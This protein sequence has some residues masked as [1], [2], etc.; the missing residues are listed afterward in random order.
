[1]SAPAF[2]QDF[3]T[4]FNKHCIDCHSGDFVEGGLD[5]DELSRDFSDAEVRRRWT[6]LHDR[7]ANGEMPPKEKYKPDNTTRATFLSGLGDS[8]TK[9]DLESR[10]VVLRRLNRK[11]YENTVR[12]LFGIYIELHRILPDETPE[13]GFDKIGSD[14]SVSAE[15]MEIYLQAADLV[16]DQVFGPDRAPQTTEI[17][18]NL[19]D[20]RALSE[21]DPR[22]DRGAYLHSR[23]KYGMYETS[24]RAPGRYRFNIQAK[25]INTDK[26]MVLNVW[27][28]NTGAIAPH[29]AG[30]FLVY[31][32]EMQT[33]EVVDWS[34]ERGDSWALE[35]VHGYSQ[36]KVPDGYEG[37]GIFVTDVEVEGPL[38]EWPPTSRS[39]L[40]GNIDLESGTIQN[41]QT[42]LTKITPRVFR[43]TTSAEELEP[44]LQLAQ[45]ALDEG[46]GF[47]RGLRRALKGIL[48][49]PEFLYLEES[50]TVND[51]AIAARLSYFLW[52]STP[53]D[54]LL[55]L[56]HQELLR[57]PEILRQQVERML[58]DEK[59]QRFVE[60]FTAQWLRLQDIDF[61]VPDR[62][63]YPEY[64]QLLRE[65]MLDETRAFFREI[66]DN[67]LSV[68]NFIDS[69]FAMLNQPLAEFYGIE[70]IEG[71][72]VKRVSLP[73]DSTRGGVLTQ[74]SVLK[75]S[76]DGTRTS[77][78]LRGVWILKHM[79]GKPS[80]P[81]PPSVEIVEPD[82]RGAT[83]IR[84]Q[85]EK[86]REHQS[87]NRCHQNIDPPG[88]ALE[89]FDVIGAQRDWYRVRRDGKYIKKLQ[90]NSPINV[91]Y[92]QGPDVD[93]TGMMP[94]G[95]SFA[96]V[97]EYKRLLLE[98]ETALAEALT[99]LLMSYGLGRNMGFSD[100]AEIARIVAELKDSDYGLR[101]M[102][103]AIV[104]SETYRSP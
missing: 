32:G 72:E 19:K 68:Q 17:K 12:D 79:Y 59:S 43:R 52:N 14:L 6:Y 66:L 93:A 29:T 41:I 91:Q 10:E 16:L 45:Q 67:D 95:R 39:N 65:S 102:I 82:I 20:S 28:G 80:P 55:S 56:A 34:P 49:A 50:Q 90:P 11:E 54:T 60:D 73:D 8:L 86:H 63:L 30:M 61:T 62:R 46:A 22:D 25:A 27:N 70:G 13:F 40:L 18:L 31:P 101:S 103:H 69:D 2:A 15:Q 42:I 23:R 84:E 58:D 38:D 1:M 74:A 47:E 36:Y 21:S 77:P 104:Q 98:D 76:A 96:D 97:R 99:S 94:D 53:D 81:P 4:F 26:P 48:C 88:F 7:V 83:T 33:I 100:R 37:P 64:N 3:D 92:R 75:V 24:V 9:A 51:N 78:V 35:L 71:I 57:K 85:L 89:S 44:Y 87:C 5:L